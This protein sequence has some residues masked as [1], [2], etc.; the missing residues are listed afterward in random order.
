MPMLTE[1]SAEEYITAHGIHAA[2]AKALLRVA[3]ER[4]SNPIVSLGEYIL[5]DRREVQE[6]QSAVKLQS[7]ARGKSARRLPDGTRNISAAA[8]SASPEQPASVA[9]AGSEASAAATTIAGYMKCMHSRIKTAGRGE[10]NAEMML[11]S[12]VGGELAIEDYGG[13]ADRHASLT[14]MLRKLDA[15]GVLPDFPLTLVQTGDR[16]IARRTAADGVELHQW[17]SQPV[18]AELRERL[19]LRR[20]LSMCSTPKYADVPIPDWCFDSWPEA[21]VPQGE[22]DAACAALAKDGAAPPTDGRVLSWC[23]TAHHHPS[24]LKLVALANAH[25]SRL[26]CVDVVDKAVDPKLHR[27]LGAQARTCQYLLDIQGKGYSS[28]LKLLLHTGRTVFIVRRP[29]LEYYFGGLHPMVHF[30]PVAEDLSDLLERLDWADAHPEEAK[31]IGAAGQAFAQRFL[32]EAAAQRSL[33]QAL[34]SGTAWPPTDNAAAGGGAGGG[35]G[36]AEGEHGARLRQGDWATNRTAYDAVR[37]YYRWTF[38]PV[39]KDRRR[40]LALLASRGVAQC[41]DRDLYTFGVYT[42]ASLKFWFEQLEALRIST[43][44]HWGFDSFEGLPEETDGMALECN[45]WKPGSFSAADQ[46]GAYTFGEV[47]QRIFEYLGPTY[48]AQTQLI[49]G[50]FSD[51]LTPMLKAEKKMKPALI[52][53]CDV[54]LYI[55]TVQCMSWMIEHGLCV[56][57]TIVYYDDVSI[58]K[59][60]TGGELKAHEELT[61]KYE[62]EWRKLHDCCWECLAV[63]NPDGKQLSI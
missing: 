39:S 44:P 18:P 20:V 45:A 12:R 58:V 22:F 2:I 47:R 51:S 16:C 8:T 53:D 6:R 35:A 63:N 60:D 11:V 57:G 24:R 61:V 34:T 29:W 7:V 62:I 40:P 37:M 41:A 49:K 21:G 54:D 33:A 3:R 1:S 46:F 9:S 30:V 13:W 48:A 50:F 27:T 38:M 42:G 25:P 14:R 55:S 19:P 23:G 31:A 32:T 4:P 15:A 10:Q 52:I 56:A 17:Q 5:A 43:G 26:A 28:R 36:G 59:A